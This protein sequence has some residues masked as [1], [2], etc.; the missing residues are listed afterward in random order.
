MKILLAD[1]LPQA[2]VARLIAAGDE[3]VSRP[4]LSDEDLPDAI[5]GF[6]A[7]VVRSTRITGATIAAADKLGIIVRA[8]AGTNTI[9]CDAAADVGILVCNVPGRNAL[10]VAELTLGLLISVDRHIADATADLRN[11]VWNKKA[12]SKGGGLFGHTMAVIGLG[13][14]GLAV[15][16]RAT[17]FGLN[18]V[19]V[20]KPGRSAEAL[21]R[22]DSAGIT[23]VD[24]TATLLAQSDIVSLHVPG[25]PDTKGLVDAEF[26]ALMKD[27]AILLNTSRGDV[28]DEAALI[29][30]MDTRGLRAGLDVFA[31]EPGRGTGEFRSELAR[32]PNVS[33]THH[34]GAST[35]QAQDAVASGTVDA[36][37]AYRRGHPIDC[38]NIEPVPA[39]AATLSIRHR[40]RVGVLAAI[41]A[42]LRT[43]KLNV[44]TMRNQ[45]FA[46]SKAAVATIDVGHLPSDD[47]VAE[48]EALAD[49]INVAVTLP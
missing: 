16:E 44:S 9:D 7:L 47:V 43:A 3:V 14:I 48:I 15:A 34:I 32:H 2:A 27:K 23:F 36:I 24:D 29:E 17:A 38:V 1:S 13:E 26:L 45:V 22:A 4:E 18:V 46:G 28:V 10:A 30:A 6:Q 39:R 8:G 31:K 12:Y 20:E 37:N 35:Q 33:A 19:A 49:V 21:A 5:A 11:G 40:D 25:S 41:L 42:I